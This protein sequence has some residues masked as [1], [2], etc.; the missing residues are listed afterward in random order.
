MGNERQEPMTRDELAKLLKEEKRMA[1]EVRTKI[2]ELEKL[3]AQHK[4]HIR[5]IADQLKILARDDQAILQNAYAHFGRL[6]M[7]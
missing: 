1:E 3:Q 6:S 2:A 7:V 4:H 5:E